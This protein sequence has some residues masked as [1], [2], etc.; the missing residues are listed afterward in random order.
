LT[1]LT[2]WKMGVRPYGLTV[3]RLRTLSPSRSDWSLALGRSGG[4]K[5]EQHGGCWTKKIVF[6]R[7]SPYSPNSPES[8]INK[9]LKAREGRGEGKGEGKRDDPHAD[10]RPVH[11]ALRAVW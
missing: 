11:R 5:G 3:C 2:S 1:T 8:P 6:K 10:K 7:H 4:R 9:G